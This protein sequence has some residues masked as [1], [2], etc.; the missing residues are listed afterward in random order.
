LAAMNF[1]KRFETKRHDTGVTLIE[2]LIAMAI[3]GIMVAGIIG[4]YVQSQRTAEWSAYNLAAQSLALQPVEQSR[5]AKWE[6]Y[7]SNPVDEL[8]NMPTRTTNVLDVPISGTSVVYATNN[9][10]VR[11]VSTN[12]PL[13]EIYVEC[14]WRLLKR[15]VFTNWVLTYRAPGQSGIVDD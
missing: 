10:R 9:I 1:R 2:S 15:G 7:S 5:A 14:T 12:P 4:G 13:K 3:L 8:T 11:T 6:P